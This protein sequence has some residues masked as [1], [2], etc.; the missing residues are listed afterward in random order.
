MLRESA[1]SLTEMLMAL[2]LVSMSV[3]GLNRLFLEQGYYLRY[4]ARAQFI[5]HLQWH[6]ADSLRFVA[7]SE[8]SQAVDSMAYWH[9]RLK[10]IDPQAD[11]RVECLRVENRWLY[12]IRIRWSVPSESDLSFSVRVEAAV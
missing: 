6:L 7:R 1:F 9:Q 8:G 4:C 5:A 2:V 10:E 11:L 3:A 12:T